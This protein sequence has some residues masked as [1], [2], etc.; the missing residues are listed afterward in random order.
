[1][2]L[3]SLVEKEAR[4][5]DE[6][7]LVASVLSNRLRLRIPLAC[8]P[9]IIYALKLEDRY[10]GNLRKADL[11]LPSAYNTYLHA[12]LPPGPIA[13]PG[14]D[15]LP[16]ALDPAVTEYLYY[17]SKNDGTHVFSK[18][19]RSHL[20]AVARYQRSAPPRRRS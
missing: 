5:P 11:N 2:T 16:A 3:A 17:V 12:G 4:T 7:R 10:D 20:N 15:S 19:L 9:T 18:D 13:N 14:I 6:R 1:V 8:D